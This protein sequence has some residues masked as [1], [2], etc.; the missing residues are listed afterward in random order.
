M[1]SSRKYTLLNK[2]EIGKIGTEAICVFPWIT[3]RHF[4]GGDVVKYQYP[5]SGYLWYCLFLPQ[6]KEGGVQTHVTRQA[7]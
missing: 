5:E 2:F 6:I 3:C 7:F 4:F 1:P